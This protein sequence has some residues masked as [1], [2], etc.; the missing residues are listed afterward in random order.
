VV[1]NIRLIRFNSKRFISIDSNRV[2]I[3]FDTFIFVQMIVTSSSHSIM[4]N[5]S[6]LNLEKAAID[7]VLVD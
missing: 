2:Q 1:C 6:T 7:P 3:L 5:V 4:H